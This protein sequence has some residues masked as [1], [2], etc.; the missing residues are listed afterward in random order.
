MSQTSLAGLRV[1]EIGQHIAVPYCT[2]LLADLG[3]DVIKIERPGGDPLRQWGPFPGDTPDPEKSALFHVLNTNKRGVTLDL[4]D[5]SDREHFRAGPFA[6]FIS[7]TENK[8]STFALP[9][10]SE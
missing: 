10:K 4:R 6:N 9:K 2:K 1:L 5:P 7:Y 8:Y 3:A